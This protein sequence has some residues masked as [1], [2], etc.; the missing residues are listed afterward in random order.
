MT[1]LKYELILDL[2]EFVYFICLIPPDSLKLISLFVTSHT[3][4]ACPSCETSV[5]MNE[6][7]WR[8]GGTTLTGEH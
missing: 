3:L 2:K 8:V 7:V 4:P 5:K 6:R 1:C